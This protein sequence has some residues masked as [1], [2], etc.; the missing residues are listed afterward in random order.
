[1]ESYIFTANHQ[2]YMFRN[3]D[4]GEINVVY[5]RRNGDYG[6]LEPHAEEE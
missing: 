4:S 1:M 2:F 6:L 3:M 5:K